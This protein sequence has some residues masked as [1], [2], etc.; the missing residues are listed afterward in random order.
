MATRRNSV[1]NMCQRQSGPRHLIATEED[2]FV[3]DGRN[4]CKA[5]AWLTKAGRWRMRAAAEV[6]KARRD[7]RLDALLLGREFLF[8]SS[9]GS[10]GR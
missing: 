6:A 2:M 9:T 7:G 3:F 4:Y 8:S 5:C 10:T 1:G